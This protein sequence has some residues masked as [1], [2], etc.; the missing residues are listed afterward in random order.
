LA[1]VGGLG[2]TIITSTLDIENT[3]IRPEVL[4]VT[5]RF[6]GLSLTVVFLIPRPKEECHVIIFDVHFPMRVDS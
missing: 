6:S 5:E 4:I 2:I 3:R 1:E